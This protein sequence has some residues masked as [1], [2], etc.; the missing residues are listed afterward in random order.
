MPEQC[1]R[2]VSFR[3]LR[4]VD[5]RVGEVG[6]KIAAPGQRALL[7]Q[8]L[9]NAN[10]TVSASTLIDGIW[11][12]N[13][14]KHP[15]SA[16]H[17]VVCRLRRALGP[18]APRLVRDCSG[19]RIEVDP[20]ELDLTRAELLAERANQLL[21]EGD[22]ACAA[23]VFDEALGCWTGEPL[24]DVSNF[25]LY[26]G[27]TRRLRELRLGIVEAR[28]AAYLR[29]GRH[30]EV[31]ADIESWVQA[32]PWRERLRAHQMV[33]LYRSGRQIDALAAY[34]DLRTLLVNDF[35][36]EPHTDLKRLHGRILR[37]DPALLANRID[38]QSRERIPAPKTISLTGG[39]N[40]VV[41]DDG[42]LVDR[43][44]EI[45]RHRDHVV[46]VDGGPRFQKAWLVAEL[47]IRLSDGA[48]GTSLDGDETLR[49][50]SLTDWLA[51]T[52]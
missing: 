48:N 9:V 46:L 6:L 11:G 28:N 15:E 36:V 29:S 31:L 44:R 8:L 18:V 26:G 23:A 4:S 5:V 14:P 45:S 52:H 35:G 34:E 39:T 20:A 43:L 32:E 38:P 7:A 10:Q 22:A 2:M 3:V 24:A 12:G 40:G 37:R 17:I 1:E 47:P 16:L 50:I 21:R 42:A 27:I 19:Y 25:P 41:D 49:C 33:A 51:K 30:L 13:S